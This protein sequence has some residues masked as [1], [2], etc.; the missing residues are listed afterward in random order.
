M[1][2][3]ELQIDVVSLLSSSGHRDKK[4]K[5]DN[6]LRLGQSKNSRFSNEP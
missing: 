4:R 6:R 5:R 1:I 2:R 3:Y